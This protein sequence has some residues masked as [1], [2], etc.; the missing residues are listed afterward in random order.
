[1]PKLSVTEAFVSFEG[2]AQD[3]QKSRKYHGGLD[4]AICLYSIELY[5]WL[6]TKGIDLP[7]GSVGEN[8]TTRGV[9]LDTLNVGDRLQVGQ[10]VIELTAIREPCRNLN[11]IHPELL[12]TI[13]GHSGWVAKVVTEGTVQPADPI[14]KAYKGLIDVTAMKFLWQYMVFADQQVM[15]AAHSVDDA[16]YYAAQDISWGSLHKQIAHGVRAQAVWL[17]RLRGTDMRYPTEPETVSR[18]TLVDEC[19][20]VNR[21]LL[22]FAAEQTPDSLTEPIHFTSRA[23]QKFA[24]ARWAG[25]AHVADHATYHRGHINTMIKR[26]GGAPSGVMLYTFAISQGFGEEL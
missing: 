19:E 6:R 24:L 1:M 10:V 15:A 5:D 17:K 4:R 18:Q 11:K 21:E 14:T 25:M 9:D 2:V 16:G 3:W 26:A 12:K 22:S 20:S 7:P 13:Q 8:F 23:G